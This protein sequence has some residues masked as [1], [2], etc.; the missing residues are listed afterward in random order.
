MILLATGAA[1]AAVGDLATAGTVNEPVAGQNSVQIALNSIIQQPQTPIVVTY[2]PTMSDAVVSSHLAGTVV[3]YASIT[4][5]ANTAKVKLDVPVLTGTNSSHAK[6][7]IIAN[8]NN[9]AGDTDKLYATAAG[10]DTLLVGLVA[11]DTTNWDGGAT[12]GLT[13]VTFYAS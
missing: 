7:S 6:V 9:S 3:Q 12:T 5:P 4:V 11:S 10:G 8:T 1:H 13:T 2:S